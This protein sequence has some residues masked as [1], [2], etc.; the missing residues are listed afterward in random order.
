MLFY[1]HIILLHETM[2]PEINDS[3]NV[4]KPIVLRTDVLVKRKEKALGFAITS[5]EKDDYEACFNYFRGVQQN[6]L[7]TYNKSPNQSVQTTDIE[8]S[9]R[10]KKN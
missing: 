5:E 2:A 9:Y 4:K 3:S 10:N 6:E 7:N 8:E 1:L